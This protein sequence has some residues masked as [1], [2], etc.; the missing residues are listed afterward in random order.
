[1]EHEMSE[2]CVLEQVAPQ[3]AVVMR[4]RAAADGLPRQFFDRYSTIADYLNRLGRTPA[5]PPFA[6]YDNIDAN[7]ADV[8]AGFAIA[9]AVEGDGDL[10]RSDLSGGQV[11][12]L[13]HVGAYTQLDASYEKLLC[14]IEEQGLERD[15]PC[16]ESY[17]N[18]PL[19]T[20]TA[21]LR[22]KILL[23]VVVESNTRERQSSS[24]NPP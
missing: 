23:S 24:A 15:G 20:P 14:W 12:T 17:L 6:I 16:M 18:S 7:A 3:S 4:F 21:E 8:E 19:D 5:S 10:I 1:M 2:A 11:A 13:I 22:T 9:S